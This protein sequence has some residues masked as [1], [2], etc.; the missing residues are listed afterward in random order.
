MFNLILWQTLRKG[1]S[2]FLW[3]NRPAKPPLYFSYKQGMILLIR[4]FQF[5]C[6]SKRLKGALFLQY[7]DRKMWTSWVFFRTADCEPSVVCL[8]DSVPYN[9]KTMCSI[10]PMR[11]VSF[12]MNQPSISHSSSSEF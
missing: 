12:C 6:K 3:Y 10:N 9:V 7:K 4:P 5:V 8:W 2:V 1:V 11:V